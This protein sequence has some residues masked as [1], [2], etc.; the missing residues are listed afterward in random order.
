MILATCMTF[1]QRTFNGQFSCSIKN[2]NTKTSN[3]QKVMLI[4]QQNQTSLPNNP[5]SDRCGAWCCLLFIVAKYLNLQLFTTK[6]H[7]GSFPS[8]CGVK[9]SSSSRSRRGPR[10]RT[11]VEQQNDPTRVPRRSTKRS[12]KHN[13]VITAF[14]FETM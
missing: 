11:K 7:H 9:S 14:L 4:R 3:Q 6:P 10:H 8:A 5:G 13:L 12:A 1:P 2:L